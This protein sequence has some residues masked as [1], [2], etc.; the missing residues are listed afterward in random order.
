MVEGPDNRAF[1]PEDLL[2]ADEFVEINV[3]DSVLE[4][5]SND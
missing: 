5:S 1:F 2:R 3:S 4:K